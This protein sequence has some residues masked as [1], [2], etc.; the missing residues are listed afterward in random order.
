MPNPPLAVWIPILMNVVAL[1]QCVLAA[2]SF[3]EATAVKKN[4]KFAKVLGWAS[5]H[6]STR[7]TRLA[8][9]F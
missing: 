8:I 2:T 7:S 4:A 1:L 5:P 3:A 9:C 6:P